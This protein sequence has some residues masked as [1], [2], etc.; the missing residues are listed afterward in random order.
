[1]TEQRS[2]ETAWTTVAG[3]IRKGMR[4]LNP[5]GSCIGI[6]SGMK[7]EEIFLDGTPDDQEHDFIVITQVDGVDE[8]SVLLSG[9]G[10]ATFG[11]GGTP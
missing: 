5:D 2:D 3:T 10:D 6:V 7:G 11:L 9:R 1:M 4:V 8:T